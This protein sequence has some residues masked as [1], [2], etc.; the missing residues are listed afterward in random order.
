M[1]EISILRETFEPDA[2]PS[3]DAQQRARLALQSRIDAAGIDA[4]PTVLKR[5]RAWFPI[6]VGMTAAAAIAA[7]FTITNL[8]RT[9]PAAPGV[10]Q[11]SGPA[12]AALPYLRPVSAA[13][14]LENAAWTV[15]QE[16]WVDPRPD[17]F[18]YVETLSLLNEK[19]YLNAHPNGAI[20]PGKASYQVKQSWMRVDGQVRAYLENGKLQVKKQ[21]DDR[22]YWAQVPYSVIAT[23]TTPKKIS[24]W[25]NDPTQPVTVDPAAMAGQFALPPDVRAAIYRYLAQQPGMKVNPKAVTIDGHPAIG[26]G[27]VLEGYLSEELLFDKDTYAL[28][29]DRYI[30]V[31]DHVNRGDDG[32]SYTHKGDVFRQTVYRKLIIV[33][34]PGDTA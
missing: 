24:T 26:M 16:K 20:V 2:A 25:L 10:Q 19:S 34:K 7:T 18:M 8:D 1:D 3:D 27:R 29:G 5:R 6:A 33:A 17:Q 12:A 15:E 31:A 30:A 22:G 28:I 14:Y 21:G 4:R 23:L 32:T 13:Q 11:E 9:T